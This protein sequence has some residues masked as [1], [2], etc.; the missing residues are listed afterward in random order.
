[1]ALTHKELIIEVVSNAEHYLNFANEERNELHI[2]ISAID[3]GK[4]RVNAV[5]EAK[6]RQRLAD[7]TDALIAIS[8]IAGGFLIQQRDLDK[9]QS[10]GLIKVTV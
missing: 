7:V 3:D 4:L 2:L 6:M 1:M 8:A 9:L 10:S 5:S